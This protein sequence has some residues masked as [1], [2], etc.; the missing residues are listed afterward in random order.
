MQIFLPLIRMN[1]NIKLSLDTRRKKKDDSYPIIL[2]LTHFRKTTSISLGQ[3]IK[4]EFWDN[5]NEKVKRA[6]KGTS[7]VSKLNNQLLKEKT[8]G[9]DII[10][11]LNEKDEL[12]FL[13]ILQLIKKM[14]LQQKSGQ[15]IRVMPLIFGYTFRFQIPLWFYSPMSSVSSFYCT[16]SLSTG[17]S[18]VP[19]R[20]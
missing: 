9:V 13:S 20:T 11:E 6:F 1:T 2:R 19:L 8:R 3:S 5:K 7:S 14:D 15:Q 4:K 12:N 18:I 10:N 16:R 17:V